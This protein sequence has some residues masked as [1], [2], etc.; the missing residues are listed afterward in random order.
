MKRI[1]L[2]ALCFTATSVFAQEASKAPDLSFCVVNDF[3]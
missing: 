1:A 2:L 3:F